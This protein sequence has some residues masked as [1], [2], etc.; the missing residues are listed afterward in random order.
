MPPS[1]PWRNSNIAFWLWVAG[2]IVWVAVSGHYST[3]L[4]S[5][6]HLALVYG[7][8]DTTPEG[9]ARAQAA[10]RLWTIVRY[11]AIGSVGYGL[12]GVV[13]FF[14]RGY[15]VF[16]VAGAVILWSWLGTSPGP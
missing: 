12:V 9:Q 14:R 13:L 2:G 6:H 1:P 5:K 16:G 7:F 3:E 8:V 10:A 15:A 4:W 11:L